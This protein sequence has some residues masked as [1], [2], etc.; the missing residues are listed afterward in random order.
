MKT[1]LNWMASPLPEMDNTKKIWVAEIVL[2]KDD[3]KQ[4]TYFFHCPNLSAGGNQ[5]I[6]YGKH[7]LYSGRGFVTTDNPATAILLQQLLNDGQ[8]TVKPFNPETNDLS[9]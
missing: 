5:G 8:L 3:S 7:Y 1:G 2:P 9:K 6:T 4:P